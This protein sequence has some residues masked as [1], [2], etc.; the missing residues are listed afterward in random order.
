M[1]N[2]KIDNSV[3]NAYDNQDL[4]GL[5]G[6]PIIGSDPKKILCSFVVHA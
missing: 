1:Y 5:L 4:L 3:S 6:L 2:N